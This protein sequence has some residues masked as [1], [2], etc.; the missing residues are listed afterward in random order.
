M[1]GTDVAFTVVCEV[2]S[3][4]KTMEERVLWGILCET[5]VFE[6]WFDSD[7]DTAVCTNVLFW[8]SDDV[9]AIVVEL[10]TDC[11][12]AVL[13]ETFSEIVLC[14]VVLCEI[15]VVKFWLDWL[16]E[17]VDIAG[18]KV[19]LFWL[20]DNVTLVVVWLDD[21]VVVEPKTVW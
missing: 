3:L 19:V 6:F 15:S 7:V 16:D 5:A 11:D 4:I 18:W 17:A 13:T 12:V 21:K 1:L 10:A 20:S 9:V 14:E 2:A 8:L